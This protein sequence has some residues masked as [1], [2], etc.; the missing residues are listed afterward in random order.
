[1]SPEGRRPEDELVTDKTGQKVTEEKQLQIKEQAEKTPR[2][3][4]SVEPTTEEDLTT[5]ETG[6]EENQSVSMLVLI[7][8]SLCGELT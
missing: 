3:P 6:Q 8:P 2:S 1:M 5:R 7:Y 4:L